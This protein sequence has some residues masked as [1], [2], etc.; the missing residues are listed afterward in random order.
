MVKR[1]RV[2]C[3]AV[4]AVVLPAATPG[5]AL[6]HDSLAPAG[7]S[8]NWLPDEEWVHRHWLPFDERV[9]TRALGLRSLELE[10]YLYNDH[11]TL[12]DLARARG[13]EVEA[14]ADQL[15]AGWPEADRAVPR[16][17]TLR[18]LTQGHL[19]QHMFFHVFHGL[20]LGGHSEH[21]FGMPV[22]AYR[23]LREK[24]LSYAQIAERGGEPVSA[25]RSL[26]WSILSANRRDGVARGEAWPA[27]ARRILAR[28]LARL[29]CWLERP[30]PELDPSNPYGKNRFLHGSHDAAWPATEAERR[31]NE[32][33]V[34]RIRRK[35]ARSCWPHPPTWGATE[36]ATR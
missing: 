33:R 34:E 7:A 6:A 18:I 15:V 16:A 28:T 26:V 32:R 31:V 19:A 12:A 23:G 30:S 8:H 5:A 1:A 27:E 24:G 35:L 25:L 17:R 29:P 9:L 3:L 36:E 20:D 21:V 11:H 13:L 22:L 4:V 10:A 14:L 2:A